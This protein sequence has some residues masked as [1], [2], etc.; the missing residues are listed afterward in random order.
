M[1][2][3]F[4]HGVYTRK[5]PAYQLSLELK[6]QLFERHWTGM[7][8]GGTSLDPVLLPGEQSFPYWGDL[9]AQF[10]WEM[11]SLPRDPGEALGAADS[12]E[13]TI[14][15]AATLAEQ[16]PAEAAAPEPLLA[17]AKTHLLPAAVALLTDA[18][19]ASAKNDESAKT[20]GRELARITKLAVDEPLPAWLDDIQ[21]DSGLVSALLYR[22]NAGDP[23][24]DEALGVVSDAGRALQRG[25]SA[26]GSAAARLLGHAVDRGGNVLT[27]GLFDLTRPAFNRMIGMF[28]GD[29][30]VY[31]TTRQNDARGIVSHLSATLLAAREAAGP[32]VI[33]AH[34]LGGIVTYDLLSHFL[35]DLP[36]DLLVTV[37]S[38]VAHFEELKLLAASDR[39]LPDA[40]RPKVP[41][42][43]QVGRW[44]N[45]F[46][47]ADALSYVCG[48]V[49]E[50]VKDVPYNSHTHAIKAHS[51]YF[52]Q[53][54]FYKLLR[55]EIEASA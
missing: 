36:V 10:A 38:Q 55:D 39:E 33:V 18:M 34:S 41:K 15:L 52:E 24:A 28:L 31:L 11:K 37:G 29:V 22:A 4:V 46:D 20:V 21:T 25:V 8:V 48:Q 35:P 1:A 50:D 7:K 51:A 49:F 16:Y 26:I 9:G 32:L 40:S 12:A 19:I 53:R 30:F 2:L 47:R 23:K 14:A 54:D 13:A 43:S 6:R 45:V 44:I 42:P 27:R 5:G 17:I 3:I